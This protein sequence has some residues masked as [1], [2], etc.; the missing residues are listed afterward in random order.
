MRGRKWGNVRGAVSGSAA[1]P[2]APV[3]KLN[4]LSE[5]PVAKAD[6]FRDVH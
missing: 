1:R 5:R 6:G 3:P 2:V 4:F